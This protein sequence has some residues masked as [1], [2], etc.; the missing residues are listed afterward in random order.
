[1]SLRSAPQIL[2]V[3]WKIAADGLTGSTSQE[4]SLGQ[5]CVALTGMLTLPLL[6]ERGTSHG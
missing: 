4:P 6:F 1:M 3:F 2:G 5:G